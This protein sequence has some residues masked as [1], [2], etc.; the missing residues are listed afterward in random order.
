MTN[1]EKLK[2]EISELKIELENK[3][4]KFK[5]YKLL[6]GLISLA[7]VVF[8]GEYFLKEVGIGREIRLLLGLS[9]VMGWLYWMKISLK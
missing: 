4:T 1:D 3:K 2:D 5:E 7:V 8:L 9:F 6:V